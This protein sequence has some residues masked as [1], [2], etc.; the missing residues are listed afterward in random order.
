MDRT[1]TRMAVLLA[2]AACSAPALAQPKLIITSMDEDIDS[3]GNKVLSRLVEWTP[4]GNG[5]PNFS[6]APYIWERGVG[7]T[8]VPGTYARPEISR[9]SSDFSAIMSNLENLDNW[10]NLNCFAGYCFGSMTGC[11]PGDPLPTPS[12]CFIPLLTH[13]WTQST[14]WVS[15][16]SITRSLDGATGRYYGGT[17]CDQTINSP[18]DISGNGRY[19][20]GGAYD[21]PLTTSS[22]GPGFG[23]CGNFDAFRYDSQTG[24]FD[25]LPSIINSKTTR[26]DRVSNDGSVITGYDLGPIPD[27][28]GGFY[29]ARR[30]CVWT[31]G[32]QSLLDDLTSNSSIWPVNGPGTT[33]AGSPGDAFNLANFG[34]TGINL[35]RWTR[36]PNDTWVPQRLGR[37][38]DRDSGLFIDT[39][40]ALFPEAISDDGNTIVGTASYN[41]I[42]PTGTHRP[43][44]W[45]P[46][47]N[48]GVP[49]DL[50]DYIASIDPSSAIL[51]DGFLLQF[52]HNMS[53]DGNAILLDVYDGRNTCPSGTL[54]HQTSNAGIL[55]LDGSSISCDPPRIGMGPSDWPEVHYLPFGVSLN[56]SA[57]GSWPLDYLWQREDPAQPGQ[58]L[59]LPETCSDTF[60]AGVG[61]SG[62]S[63][64]FEYEG[65]HKNQ[66]RI[67]QDAEGALNRGGRYRVVVSNACGSVASEPATVSFEVG[68]CCI[69]GYCTIEYKQECESLGGRFIGVGVTCNGG[70]P[71]PADLDNGS[72]T[73]Q[74]DGAVDINDLLYF[75]VQFEAG[76][77]AADVDDG[78]ST[79][80]RDQA[81]DIN[82]LLYFLIRFEAGC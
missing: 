7:H 42:G 15:A 10:G 45:K 73:G 26:A 44:I 23:L 79:G 68:G 71:C 6:Y 13:R 51:T 62:F 40:V 37:P 58:W 12:P 11:T 70:C 36:Q 60:I 30:M 53:A 57:S 28:A 34:V 72:G 75:L 61:W 65:V 56:V 1:I 41:S 17:R 64:N 59:N 49:L 48:G 9:G 4:S 82:D 20:V 22:G 74:F 47:L 77:T 5:Y 76:T 31:N 69:S 19:I 78:S 29:D 27:G 14:G 3:T 55:Y 80:T 32:V 33:I 39:L 18:Y 2:A 21:A 66:L 16:H 46:T 8:R 24:A 43:F 67:G 38:V 35:V 50:T 63:S 54:S 52:V 81:V 25:K